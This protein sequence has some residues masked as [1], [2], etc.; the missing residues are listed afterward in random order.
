[1]I[2]YFE[3]CSFCKEEI[4]ISIALI[5]V[6]HNAGLSVIHKKCLKNRGLDETFRKQSPNEAKEI[7]EWLK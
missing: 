6:N 5:G 2:N 4:L 1:M 7:E 3:K